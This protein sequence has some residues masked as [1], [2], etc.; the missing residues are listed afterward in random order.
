MPRSPVFVTKLQRLESLISLIA[1][2]QFPADSVISRY[3]KT[4]AQL[5]SKDRAFLA[6]AAWAFLRHRTWHAHLAARASGSMHRRHAVLA[7]CE[8]AGQEAIDAELTADEKAWLKELP[9]LRDSQVA[10]HVRYSLPQWLYEKFEQLLGK[11]EAQACAQA[12]QESAPLDLRVNTIKAKPEQA[13]LMLKQAGIEAVDGLLLPEALRVRG[14]PAS[15]ARSKAFLD[16]LVE[17]QDQGSQLLARLT[18]PKRG[19]FV[20]DFC[21]GAGGK[22]LALGAALRNTGRLYAL[23]VSTT[24]LAKLKPRLARSGL[25]NVWPSAISGPSD[26]R[27]KRLLGK[28]DA[29]LVDA[30]CTG[31]GTLRRNPDLKWRQTQTSLRELNSTQSAILAVAARLLKPG[32]RLVYATC[33][34]LPEENTEIVEAFLAAHPGFVRE[35]VSV[36]LAGQK[37]SFPAAWRAENEQG[38]MMLWPHRTGTDGFFAAVLLNTGKAASGVG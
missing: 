26:D 38:D 17:V 32:G 3:F 33:S 11:E 27:V 12:L 18:A 14:K 4:H 23:D 22:T 16:G 28:A 6:E 31:L 29:V 19:Q 15:L 20:V 25:S 37:L 2:L 30:P 35:P 8:V 10:A 21:A 5:G 9:A 1:P 24:R 13:I 34:L 7:A 36:T